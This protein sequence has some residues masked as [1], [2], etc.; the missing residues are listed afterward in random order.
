LWSLATG[1]II[2]VISFVTVSSVSSATVR[3]QVLEGE[4]LIIREH[5][6]SSARPLLSTTFSLSRRE[7]LRL[8]GI[9]RWLLRS[10]IWMIVVADVVAGIIPADLHHAEGEFFPSFLSKMHEKRGNFCIF[11]LK[12]AE[13]EL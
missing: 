10:G 12:I 3:A 8:L 11:L 7:I 5:L 9:R 13:K 6:G 4:E 1:S 2:V